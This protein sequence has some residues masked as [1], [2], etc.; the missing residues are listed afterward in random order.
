V[1]ARISAVRV[2][3]AG[4]AATLVEI[5][6]GDLAGIG[7]TQSPCFAVEPIIQHPRWGLARAIVG[8]QVGE[9]EAFWLAMTRG[10]GAQRGRGVEGGL[11]VN[12]AAALDMALWDLHGKAAGKPVHALLGGAKHRSVMAYASATAVLS[13][14]YESGG[15]WIFKDAKQLAAESRTYVDQ[16]FRA[17]KFG[18]GNRFGADDEARLAAVRDAIGPEVRM[19]I[20]FGCPAYWDATWSLREAQRVARLLER[21]DVYFFEEPLSP[22][23]GYDFKRLSNATST[24]I[25]TGESLCLE[26]E[27]CALID[28]AS[29]AVVQPD[30][31]Q[32]GITQ[33]VR[34]ARHA[35][36]AG[37]L[38]VPHSPWSALTVASH[39]HILCTLDQESM[40]EYPAMASFD[41]GS[42]HGAATAFH[43][44]AVV[45]QPP[46]L[47]EGRV[48]ISDAPGL[49]LGGF[50]PDAIA[51]LP[52]HR[53]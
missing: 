12:A 29:V 46:V 16:G 42:Q 26:H 28:S 13:S 52:E 22:H 21:Y 40:V 51:R 30:A 17:V 44:F 45:E 18:W 36:A 1:S 20:D 53:S 23:A 15:E 35:D 9:V 19:M 31:A 7:I 4:V 2:Y 43:N 10:F 32:I 38:C 34:V 3:D 5:G 48:E 47:R 14:S 50:V 6:A 25:A 39:A 41:R 8:E 49:G 11:A 27:F 33:A 24:R 37:V